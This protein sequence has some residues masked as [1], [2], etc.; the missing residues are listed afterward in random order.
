MIRTSL[1]TVYA[2]AAALAATTGD[3]LTHLTGGA[4]AAVLLARAWRRHHDVA[5]P[6]ARPTSPLAQVPQA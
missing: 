6:A 1:S 2:G 4:V 3:T 5:T